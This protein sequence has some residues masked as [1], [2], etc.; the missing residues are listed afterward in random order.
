M[1][2]WL[3]K[4]KKIIL[5][6]TL[7]LQTLGS[8]GVTESFVI[9]SLG[10]SITTAT[11][12]RGWGDQKNSNWS[13]GTENLDKVKS[14]YHKLKN[15][16]G[17]DIK[18][19]NV[20]RAGSTSEDL[21]N[22]VTKLISFNPDYVTLLIGANDVC[23]WHDDHH[24][25]LQRFKNR[26]HNSVNRLIEHN[27]EVKILL[28]PVPDMYHLWRLGSKSSCQFL[29]DMA[30]VC[31]RLLHSSTPSHKK[32]EFKKRLDDL[33]K[34][35]FQVANDHS[36]H[37]RFDFSLAEYKFKKEDVSR[38]DCFHPSFKGQNTISELTWQ[39]S[40]Y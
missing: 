19:V 11:N 24:L 27:S 14:H 36:D 22:Q 12:A 38:S 10:D 2:C 18:A 30:N 3:N 5:L 29:W 16:F 34:S 25:Q 23:S 33:N 26:I 15:F 31:P 9:G 1:V 8:S 32:I 20:A 17:E 6:S 35:L 13:T 39:A 28:V 40:W 7:S 4:I 21:S 37:V